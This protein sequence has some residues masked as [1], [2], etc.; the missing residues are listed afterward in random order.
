MTKQQK[1]ISKELAQK[2][3]EVA[4]I[5]HIELAESECVWIDAGGSKREMVV[6]CGLNRD[7]ERFYPAYDTSELGKMLPKDYGSKKV[8]DEYFECSKDY[9]EHKHQE[10]AKTEAECRGQMYLYL[11]E[12]DLLK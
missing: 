10:F 5:K 6:Y 7:W 3:S 1:V 9:Q 2:I 4:K 11:M 8:E 12:N